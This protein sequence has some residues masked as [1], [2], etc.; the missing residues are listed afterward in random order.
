MK[1]LKGCF[2]QEQSYFHACNFAQKL[3]APV[4]GDTGFKTCQEIGGEG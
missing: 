2:L 1:G 4:K 3:N